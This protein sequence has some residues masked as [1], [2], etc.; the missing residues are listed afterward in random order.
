MLENILLSLQSIWAHKLRSILT[1]LGVIIG[2]AAIIAIFGIIEGNTANMKKNILGGSNNTI[3]LEFGPLSQ[4][5]P[6]DS[7]GKEEQKPNYIPIFSKQEMDQIRNAPNVKNASL[8]FEKRT[9]IFREN[10]SVNEKVRAI[11]PEYFQLFPQKVIAG[12]F[13]EASDYNEGNQVALLTKSSYKNLFPNEDGIGQIIEINGAPFQ[14]I[15]IV[16]DEKVTN[17]YEEN[18]DVYVPL[19]TWPLI[20]E[21]INPTPKV[22]VQATDSDNLKSAAANA[23]KLLNNWIPT[24][25]YIFGL[26]DYSSF[27]KS[28]EE[29]NQSQFVLLA[30]IASIS[31]LVGGIG[32]MNIMLV[33]VTERTREIGVKKALGARRKIILTQFLVESVTLTVLGGFLGV[34]I[35][36]IIAKILTTIFGFPYIISWLAILGSLGFCMII[37]IVF[38]LMPAIKAS[39]LDPI[40]ALRYE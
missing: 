30:G 17:T 18:R 11:T 8:S 21:G 6:A 36:L 9:S 7:D 25:D 28:M 33:S 19:D 39:K 10:N 20:S 34:S 40:E 35:G 37:G 38:G 16:E 5:S 27:E 26:M 14:V 3:E 12:R 24:S 4:F 23:A 2:I 15:G 32:V 22:I 1:M 31:L 29:M 13:F